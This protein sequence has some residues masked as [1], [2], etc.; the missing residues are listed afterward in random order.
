MARYYT[1]TN[2]PT[3]ARVRNGF[4]GEGCG[5]SS[6][7]GCWPSTRWLPSVLTPPG[8]PR[9]GRPQPPTWNRLACHARNWAGGDVNRGLTLLSTIEFPLL[10][11]SSTHARRHAVTRGS[12]SIELKKTK[13]RPSLSLTPH[14]TDGQMDWVRLVTIF[15]KQPLGIGKEQSKI[16]YTRPR[17]AQ[18]RLEGFHVPHRVA[19]TRCFSLLPCHTT[20]TNAIAAIRD[21]TTRYRTTST[22]NYKLAH[23]L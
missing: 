9:P 20:C 7:G 17:R 3:E 15:H 6:H 12:D 11:C 8:S 16:P 5:R 10:A 19:Q 22:W 4:S 21:S 2:T 18:V 14:T 1:S 13:S 23:L